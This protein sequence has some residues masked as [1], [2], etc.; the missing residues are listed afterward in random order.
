MSIAQFEKIYTI[1]DY[2]DQPREGMTDYTGQPHYYK[3]LFD[4]AKDSWSNLYF[5]KPLDP[6]TFRL[7]IED[8]NLWLQWKADLDQGKVTLDSHPALSK[9][10]ERSIDLGTTLANRLVIDQDKDIK[11]EG[12]FELVERKYTGDVLTNPEMWRV[13]WKQIS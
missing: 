1:T 7:A 5:L 4:E 13:L 6:E 11:A 8:W 3:C 12:H 2:W 10:K 9:N